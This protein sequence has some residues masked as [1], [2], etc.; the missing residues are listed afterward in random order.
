VSS[1]RDEQPKGE[2]VLLRHG[3]TAWSDSGKHTGRTDVPLT[4]DGERQAERVGRCFA[5]RTFVITLSSPRVRARRTAELAGLHS[6]EIDDDLQEWDYGGY[7]GLTTAEIRRTKP[8]WVLWR[9]GVVAPSHGPP[10]GKPTDGARLALDTASVSVLGFEHAE[11]VVQ[12]WNVLA[13][14]R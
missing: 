14:G 13:T 12:H 7:E 4:A 1:P 5:D 8:G 10:R 6:I 2:I 11:H 9:D 3:A